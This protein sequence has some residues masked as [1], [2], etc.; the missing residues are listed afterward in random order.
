MQPVAF[1]NII[2]VELPVSRL[3][4]RTMGPACLGLHCG[5]T[6]ACAPAPCADLERNTARIGWSVT[7]GSPGS[8][9]HAKFMCPSG[10]PGDSSAQALCCVLCN[11]FAVWIDMAKPELL[12]LLAAPRG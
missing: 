7:S 8:L 5:P 12:V 9:L 6:H 4:S 3:I 2:R 11:C 1:S 10:D